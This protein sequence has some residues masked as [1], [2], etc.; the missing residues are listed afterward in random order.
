M[1]NL[2]CI[3]RNEDGFYILDTTTNKKVL[4]TS[5]LLDF[6]TID[7]AIDE[8]Q[9]IINADTEELKTILLT[10]LSKTK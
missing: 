3:E 9:T 5:I 4:I 7:E 10:R 6:V 8:I 2:H 1:S